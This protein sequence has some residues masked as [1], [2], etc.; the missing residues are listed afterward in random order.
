MTDDSLKTDAFDAFMEAIANCQIPPDVMRQ[1]GQMIA[2]ARKNLRKLCP[3]P[4]RDDMSLQLPSTIKG[5]D[6]P[7]SANFIA[8]ETVEII[9]HAF[10]KWREEGHHGLSPVEALSGSYIMFSRSKSTEA[11]SAEP[12]ISEKM[13]RSNIAA[14]AKQVG[15][16]NTI[17][18]IKAVCTM[19]DDVIKAAAQEQ[20]TGSKR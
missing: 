4:I 17:T 15:E 16:N 14:L 7:T 5:H 19:A 6:N 12:S 8:L 13:I 9:Q 11:T 2:D 18:V 1:K 10:S 3:I 20:S